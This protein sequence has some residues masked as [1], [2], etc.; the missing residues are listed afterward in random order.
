MVV[1]AVTIGLNVAFARVATSRSMRDRFGGL[2]YPVA[3]AR[4]VRGHRP[5]RCVV[6][7][8]GTREVFDAVQVSVSNA[9]VFGG[10]LGFRVP[11][12]DMT[13]GLL[14]VIVVERLSPARLALAVADALVGRH[15]PV[16]GVHTRRARVVRIESD[17]PQEVALDG[18]LL[19]RLPITCRAEPSTLHL[20]AAPPPPPPR[21]TLQRLVR[22]LRRKVAR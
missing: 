14:D 11:G 9:P 10:L 21:S 1:N 16:R 20:L 3:A 2:T 8:D 6:V 7:H 15:R 13:D 4:A 19:G 22:T 17:E 18:E 5:F 12:A